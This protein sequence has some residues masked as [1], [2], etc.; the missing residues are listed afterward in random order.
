[1]KRLLVILPLLALVTL[2][3]AQTTGI[4][5]T[6]TDASTGKPIP[7]AKVMATSGAMAQTDSQ[8][9]YILQLR[10]GKYVVTA[11]A[12]GYVSAVYPETVV[13]VQ[14]QLTENID[15]ALQPQGGCPKGAIAGKVTNSANGTVI[16]GAEV[17]ATG[18]TGSFHVTQGSQGYKISDLPAGKYWVSAVARGFEPGAYPES[19]VVTAGQVTADINFSLRP[20]GGNEPGA[21]R[22]RVTDAKTGEPIRGAKVGTY[23]TSTFTD[24]LGR[25]ILRNL[26]PGKYVVVAGAMGYQMEVYPE[27][28]VVRPGQTVE[29]IDFELMPAGGPQC[30][31]IAGKVTDEKSGL[32]IPGALVVARNE[33][34]VRQVT[35]CREGYRIG[36]LPPGKY[37]V[38][39][40]APGYEPG[41]YPESVVVLAGEVTEDVN[42][43]LQPQEGVEAGGISGLVTDAETGKPLFGA[44]VYATGPTPSRTNTNE[45]GEYLLKPLRP[46][47]YRVAV[48]ARGYLPS[49]PITV[50]VKA[51]EITTDVNF[52]LKPFVPAQPGYISG[53]VTDAK[54]GEP[55][56]R[57]VVFAR[58]P[59][60]QGKA[61]TDSSGNYLLKLRPGKYLV[62]ACGRGYYPAF[63][64]D[65]VLVTENETV[66]GIDFELTPAG[67][68]GGGIAGFVYD[69]ETQ[70]ELAGALVRATG[71]NGS[72]TT[73][74]NQYGEYLFDNLEPGDYRLEV[75]VQGYSQELY[76]EVVTVEPAD[77]ASFASPAVYPLTGIEESS[78]E[79]PARTAGLSA[80]PSLVRTAGMVKWQVPVAGKVTV[81][82][83]DKT[84][85]T[86][87][88]LQN[89]YQNSGRYSATWDGTDEQGRRL[90][91]GVYFYRLDAPQCQDIQK[92]VLLSR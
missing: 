71:P 33:Q 25:Y 12:M 82:V 92:A 22:G 91:P 3:L 42:F 49:E 34:V 84:G 44:Y 83:I 28:V 43:S 20:A 52:G 78:R 85:R 8:G 70:V 65:T 58:G 57:A 40:I 27:T 38:G 26:A 15:F 59:N 55:I 19:V 73:T 90:A 63:Y 9:C 75:V 7:R 35:Q 30:G 17:R 69:G 53:T 14:G 41:A 86:V 54:S 60:G 36:E 32:L 88:T 6:V 2:V 18:P 67:W 24:S 1:M 4:T 61:M 77:I 72:F 5:G 31:V 64:P 56:V 47:T 48:K 23:R 21:I 51:G 39:A 80:E 46:G 89:G 45:D 62:R 79:R 76:P 10:P 16:Q 81:R 68:H 11:T 87:R 29:G 66:S 13:V 74:A 50:E 37:F